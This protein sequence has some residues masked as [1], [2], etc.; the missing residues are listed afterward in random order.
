[1]FEEELRYWA[2]DSKEEEQKKKFFGELQTKVFD[3]QPTNLDQDIMS[4]WHQLGIF[5]VKQHIGSLDESLIDMK[6]PISV[7]Q[8]HALSVK[9]GQL[10]SEQRLVGIGRKEGISYIFEG[11][12]DKDFKPIFLRSI[13]KSD[14]SYYIGHYKNYERH[15]LGKFVDA[16]GQVQE[17][18]WESGA[19]KGEVNN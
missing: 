4:R 3:I 10:N 13:E 8:R 14:G 5:N 15:G 9:S 11:L 17:G 1:M 19:F 16:N 18:L 7:N 2:F 12:W 6:I